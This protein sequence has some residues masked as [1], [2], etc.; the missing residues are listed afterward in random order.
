MTRQHD[1]EHSD[2]SKYT[3]IKSLEDIKESNKAEI[4]ELASK[5][6]ILEKS[7]KKINA[8]IFSIKNVN[9][10]HIQSPIKPINE[11]K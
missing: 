7:N 11:R 3:D 8:R 6:N 2:F 9:H 4:E 1:I 10:S 5:I